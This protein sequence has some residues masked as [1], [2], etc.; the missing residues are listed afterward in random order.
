V[1]AREVRGNTFYHNTL[2]IIPSS[3]ASYENAETSA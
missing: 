2:G 3:I 1:L